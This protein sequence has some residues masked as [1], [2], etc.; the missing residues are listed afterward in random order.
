MA[1][2]GL[3]IIALTMIP[4]YFLRCLIL[5]GES[6]GLGHGHEARRCTEGTWSL[7]AVA[8]YALLVPWELPIHFPSTPR[9]ALLHIDFAWN[10]WLI[11]ASGSILYPF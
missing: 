8:L 10:F 2:W 6:L 5:V 11:L 4:A 1:L 9:P 3:L 7:A